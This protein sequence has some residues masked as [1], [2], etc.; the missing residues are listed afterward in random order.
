MRLYLENARLIDGTGRP[1]QEDAAP[2]NG[3]RRARL[4]VMKGGRFATRLASA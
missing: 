4:S 1:A 2:E 3:P